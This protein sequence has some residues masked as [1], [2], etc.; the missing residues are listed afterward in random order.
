MKT[1][2][3]DLLV[4]TDQGLWSLLNGR[5]K[6]FGPPGEHTRQERIDSLMA[7]LE[8]LTEGLPT[9]AHVELVIRVTN[10]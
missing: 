9:R 3:K 8:N 5:D 4:L 6:A 1:D 7:R 10:G 2:R